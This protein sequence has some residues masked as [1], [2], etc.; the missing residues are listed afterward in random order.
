MQERDEQLIK[1]TVTKLDLEEVK[2]KLLSV[3]SEVAD[4]PI[5]YFDN[6]KIKQE[7][8]TFYTEG[9]LQDD[10]EDENS[11]EDVNDTFYGRRNNVC[12][13]NK[14]SFNNKQSNYGNSQTK[15][16]QRPQN[17]SSNNWRD[18]NK[19]QQRNGTN[20]PN[21]L[22]QMSKC[23]ICGS[24]YHWAAS[25]PE[26]G[27]SQHTYIA[28]EIVLEVNHTKDLQTLVAETWD[29]ALLD[30]GASKT[31]C[32]K[33]W[34]DNYMNNLSSDNRSQIS[35]SDSINSYRFGDGRV[36]PSLHAA[37]IPAFIGQKKVFIFIDVVDCDIPLY[38]FQR[39]A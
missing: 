24:T 3:F 11:C 27:S 23:A 18:N 17:S 7:S 25:C 34:F 1:A 2:S 4:I 15:F 31:V 14:P 36:T 22:G 29:S 12:F 33:S 39:L 26:K 19:P 6:I 16:G 9:E 5:K 21:R 10:S 30:C 28:N 32:G 37:K 38:S 8:S 13:R 20:P 35:F